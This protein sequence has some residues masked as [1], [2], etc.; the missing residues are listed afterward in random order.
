MGDQTEKDWFQDIETIVSEPLKFKAKLAIGEDAYTS[1][2]MKNAA[3]EAWD[4]AGVAATAAGVA[5]TS[6][7]ASAFFAP[8]GFLAVIGIGTAIT[9]L[10]WV[11]GAGVVTGGAW[12]GLTRYFKSTFASRVTVIPDFINTPLDVL[13]LGLF[14]L[15][16]PLALKVADVEGHIDETERKLIDDYFVREWGYDPTFVAEGIK[17]V[18]SKLSEYSI[19]NSAEALAEVAK[20]NPD[21]NFKSMSEE[22]IEF[23]RNITEADG[24]IDERE[25]M[26]IERIESIF[27]EASS[28][29]SRIRGS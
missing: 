28:F 4:V 27:K 24:R 6:V 18:E 11:I 7:I 26:A 29:L 1:L 8:S 17:Y 16:T 20:K 5:Q 9:P 13:A 14:D 10:G 12:L 19:K 3:A 21:C 23:L 15:L 25:E 2:R 22:I